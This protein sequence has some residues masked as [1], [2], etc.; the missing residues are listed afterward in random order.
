MLD[1]L[2]KTAD[3]R[4]SADPDRIKNLGRRA[5]RRFIESDGGN[6]TES[7]S[8]IVREEGDLN[9]AQIRR[10]TEAANQSTWSETFAGGDGNRDAS[11]DPADASEVLDA[12]APEP[13]QIHDTS[14]DYDAPPPPPA[15]EL[16][17]VLS[18]FDGEDVGEKYDSID[19]GGQARRVHEKVAH[20]RS[21]AQSQADLMLASLHTKGEELYDLIK[22]AHLSGESYHTVIRVVDHACVD[23]TFALDILKIAG[24]RLRAEGLKLN[25]TKQAGLHQIVEDHPLV[26]AAAEFEAVSS[27]YIRASDLAE[28]FTEAGKVSSRLLRDKLRGV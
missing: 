1:A 8:S 6:L 11:F 23:S 5:A 4:I 7:V 12:V 2:I 25:M 10:V 13:V 24:E 19:P 26:K 22:Q 27:A 18:M 14:S 20:A 28:T 21:E 17:Q 9:R 3:A 15:G 16:D